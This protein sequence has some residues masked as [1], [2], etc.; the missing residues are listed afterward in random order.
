MKDINIIISKNLVMLRK[1]HNYKQTDIA[2]KLN[3]SDKTVSKW[4]TGEIVPSLENLIELCKLYNVTLDQM[5]KPIDDDMVVEQPRDYSS[6]N[7]LIISLLAISAVWIIA[8]IVFVYTKIILDINFWTLFVW[9]VPCSMIVAI[10]FNSMWGKSKANYVYISILT[11]SLIA[12]IYLQFLKYNLIPLFFLG[13][14]VQVAILLWSG[15][16]KRK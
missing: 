10:V 11:W 7:K 5:T 3:Y 8:T 2:E 6:R 15:I 14:P 1:R 9:A 4:E 13:I 12:S 16:R